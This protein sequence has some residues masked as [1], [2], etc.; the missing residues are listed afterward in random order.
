MSKFAKFVFVVVLFS[1]VAVSLSACGGPVC[2]D[3][4]VVLANSVSA[5]NPNG[6]CVAKGGELT[7]GQVSLEQQLNNAKQVI[8]QTKA[9]Y[10]STGM[11]TS[12]L[13]KTVN[14]Q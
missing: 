1:I 5:N 12:C 4:E 9:C 6:V 13:A 3:G 10:D 7:S 2:Q 14:G 8:D 11:G